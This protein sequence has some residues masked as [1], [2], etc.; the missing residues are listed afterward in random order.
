[1]ACHSNEISNI[2]RKWDTFKQQDDGAHARMVE[3]M[4]V[5]ILGGPLKIEEKG[6]PVDM[7]PWPESFTKLMVSIGQERLRQS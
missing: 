6:R 1:M 4:R 3:A 7:K 2:I 5:T